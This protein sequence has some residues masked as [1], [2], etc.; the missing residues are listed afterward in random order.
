MSFWVPIASGSLFLLTVTTVSLL[1]RRPLFAALL[2]GSPERETQLG[3]L[4]GRPEIRHALTGARRT[5]QLKA[6]AVASVNVAM[7]VHLVTAAFGTPKFNAQLATASALMVPVAYCA[8]GAGYGAA[9]WMVRRGL[10]RWPSLPS[11]RFPYRAM[12]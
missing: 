10:G 6:L 11:T 1:A 9:G 3:E 4:L 8:S 5:L 2:P 7:K 12:I